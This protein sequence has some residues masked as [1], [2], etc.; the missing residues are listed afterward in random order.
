M[1]RLFFYLIILFKNCAY[2]QTNNAMALHIPS[3]PTISFIALTGTDTSQHKLAVKITAHA[4]PPVI[5]IPSKQVCRQ[6]VST[7]FMVA[8]NSNVSGKT[9][10]EWPV[11][12]KD[13][14]AASQ[15]SFNLEAIP[16][17]TGTEVLEMMLKSH[18]R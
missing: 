7:F 9:L 3:S 11:A 18:G 10:N 8:G 12:G 1:Y 15:P 2:G 17:G 4:N 5:I 16:P 14:A 13:S 6:R